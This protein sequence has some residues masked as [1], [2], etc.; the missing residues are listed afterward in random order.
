MTKNQNWMSLTAK[1]LCI[2]CLLLIAACTKTAESSTEFIDNVEPADELY[3]QG[4]ANLDAGDRKEARDKFEAVDKQH[5]YSELSRKSLLMLTFMSYRDGQYADS[6]ASGKRYVSLYPGSQE[7][8]YA[9][10]LVGMSYFRQIP[11]ITRDQNVTAKAYTSMK[12]VVDRY[13][14][15]EYVED[16]KLKMRVAFD[17]I[18]G[19]EMLVGRYYQERREFLA[20]VN[21]FRRVVERFQTTRHVE[22]ALA[23]LTESYYSLG[24]ISEAQTATAVLGHNF[25][26]SQWY[27]DSYNLLS[28]GGLSPNENKNS[29]ISKI[30]QPGSNN[31]T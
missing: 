6:V 31:K 17:Q 4:L 10:Y 30:F 26:D 12:V 23:R 29:W 14:D 9:Q 2:T 20:A 18:A 16:A 15:S 27:K 11:D 19:K 13:P 7:A 3:N 28:S 21:R 1:G 25:P 22:E 24:L 5:P 8:A